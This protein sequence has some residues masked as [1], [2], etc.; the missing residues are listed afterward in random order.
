MDPA[1]SS[2]CHKMDEHPA[3][4][5]QEP[6]SLSLTPRGLRI[7]TSIISLPDL[8]SLLLTGM[9]GLDS[10]PGIGKPKAV[11]SDK[12]KTTTLVRQ[13]Q[14]WKSNLKAFPLYS[15][16]EE[17]Q[18]NN[19]R[20]S[21]H[22]DEN[23]ID[24]PDQTIIKEMIDIYDQCFLCLP[25]LNNYVSHRFQTNTLDPLLMY[26]IMA[27]TARHG[28]VHHHL[29]PGRDP[30]RVGE[31]YFE[32]AKQIL[33]DRFMVTSFDTLH[34]LLVMAIYAGGKTGGERPG[35]AESEGS[36]YLGLAVRMCLDL[37]M[38][39]GSSGVCA[40][41]QETN[42]RMVWALYFIETLCLIY[43]DRTVSLRSKDMRQVGY[44]SLMG[45]EDEEARYR[46]EFIIHRYQITRIY[47][48]MMDK[49]AEEKPLLASVLA[50]DRELE[51][52]YAALPSYLCYQP[53]DVHRR[54]WKTRSFGE[55]ACIKLNAEYNYQRC[56]LYRLFSRA[57]LAHQASAVELVSYDV[58]LQTAGILV[59][60]LECW[61][62]L[63]Q[64]WCHFSL[65]TFMMAVM[66][67]GGFLEGSVDKQPFAR[68][69]LH[70]I[71]VLLRA[72]PVSHH[73]YVVGLVRQIESLLS[74]GSSDTRTPGTLIGTRPNKSPELES[75]LPTHN[76]TPIGVP[77]FVYG[78]LMPFYKDEPILDLYT[79]DRRTVLSAPN[80]QSGTPCYNQ[81]QWSEQQSQ[82]PRTLRYEKG[83]L[84]Q[85]VCPFEPVHST[86]QLLTSSLGQIP[87]IPL[88]NHS[89]PVP[90]LPLDPKG[91]P[92]PL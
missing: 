60:L 54:V 71:T 13:K 26:A 14:L 4:N 91:L 35:Q 89:P 25:C 59:E 67:Y 81:D 41:E 66:I 8:H 77:Q 1:S 2:S 61:T 62:Q 88:C 82:P 46:V 36:I 72:S 43:T 39:L 63:D 15:T 22:V 83:V 40:V 38:H 45:D 16:W 52:W 73:S 50:I 69:Q 37:G 34:S 48:L 64:T 78:N 11:D 7:D 21:S 76:L 47:R 3:G 57:D 84:G 90:S 75:C 58:C 23:T 51:A 28:A 86:Q 92:S 65:E 80:Q 53:G 29:F 31:Q 27:W 20:H 56:Q 33:K 24:D 55:Q 32:K 44:P 18:T 68:Q 19:S 49:M 74:G 10:C 30:N 5:G 79:Q 70:K 12:N 9:S 17:P 6:W 85:S 42:R 87:T